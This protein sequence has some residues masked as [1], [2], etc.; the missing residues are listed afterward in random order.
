MQFSTGVLLEDCWLVICP[1]LGT[2]NPHAHGR[3]VAAVGVLENLAEFPL[4]PETEGQLNELTKLRID[5]TRDYDHAST[6][7]QTWIVMPL[8]DGC[9]QTALQVVRRLRLEGCAVWD[10]LRE[11][12]L[13]RWFVS[14]QTG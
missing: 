12:T 3:D 2:F 13:Q 4:K 9:P 10:G 1:Q 14:P 6:L 11:D 8:F 5:G 7:S